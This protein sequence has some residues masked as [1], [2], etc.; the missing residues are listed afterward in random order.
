MNQL[1]ALIV[2]TMLVAATIVLHY[3]IL[4]A[5]SERIL[6]IHI[7]ARTRIL[8][9]LAAAFVSHFAQIALYA[10]VYWV[11][12]DH[13][14]L[15]TIVGAAPLTPADYLYFSA[16]AYSTLGIGDIYPVGPVRLVVG[17]E[18]L[19]GLVLVGWTTSF[20]YLTMEKFWKLQR[21]RS[22]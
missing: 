11:F 22:R 12:H 19:N 9:V 2:A 21:S 3:E 1:F 14:E 17:I 15:G 13:L 6:H 16:S 4:R 20:T 7:P 8:V 10:A 18:A 5:T